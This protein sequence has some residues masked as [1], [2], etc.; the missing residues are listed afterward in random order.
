MKVGQMRAAS[1]QS[2]VVILSSVN[3]SGSKKYSANELPSLKNSFNN[4]Q[5]S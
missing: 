1:Q 5:G 2:G 4:K 3:N